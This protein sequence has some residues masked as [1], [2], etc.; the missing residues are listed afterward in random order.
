MGYLVLRAIGV[1]I[2]ISLGLKTICKLAHVYSSIYKIVA[3]CLGEHLLANG[4]FDILIRLH[5]FELKSYFCINTPNGGTCNDVRSNYDAVEPTDKCDTL[6]LS[7]HSD[8]RA[9]N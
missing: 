4:N 7:V 9:L 3:T 6:Q 5:N 2:K 8:V 1:L